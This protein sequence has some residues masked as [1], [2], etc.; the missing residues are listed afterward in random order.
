MYPYLHVYVSRHFSLYIHITRRIKSSNTSI[1]IFS[2]GLCLIC[3]GIYIHKPSGTA[4]A[5][6]INPSPYE[7]EETD[8]LVHWTYQ[9]VDDKTAVFTTSD[10]KLPPTV[11]PTSK[12]VKA[13][14][15]SLR[16]V[17]SPFDR[18]EEGIATQGS[19]RGR[20]YST[21]LNNSTS[22]QALYSGSV[23]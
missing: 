11:T 18:I 8:S 22:S 12:A 23:K 5:M 6:P 10:T 20:N 9:D 16:E 13:V 4:A 1:V 17:S 14:S 19:P 21:L 15:S 7:D 2:I 3:T